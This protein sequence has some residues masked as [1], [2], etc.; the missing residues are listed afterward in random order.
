M[1]AWVGRGTALIWRVGK[2][3]GEKISEDHFPAV[4][5]RARRISGPEGGTLVQEDGVR[6]EVVGRGEEGE[7]VAEF[8]FE[9]AG[10]VGEDVDEVDDV[11]DYCLV[12]R[13]RGVLV[14]VLMLD[15]DI[16]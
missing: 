4:P 2:R 3:V 9:V 6:A 14:L 16:V 12:T 15:G 11:G 7:E 10:V 5:L 8:E 1:L 13:G